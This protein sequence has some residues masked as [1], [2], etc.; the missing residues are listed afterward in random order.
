MQSII[1]VFQ[2]KEGLFHAPEILPR[3]HQWAQMYFPPWKV[4]NNKKCPWTLLSQYAMN[5]LSKPVHEDYALCL[6]M[7]IF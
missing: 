7:L 1:R 5:I 6:A 3:S 2:Y 4:K